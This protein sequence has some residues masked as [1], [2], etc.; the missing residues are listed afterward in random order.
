LSDVGLGGVAVG[1]THAVRV[2]EVLA[3]ELVGSV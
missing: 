1:S 2:V 3:E